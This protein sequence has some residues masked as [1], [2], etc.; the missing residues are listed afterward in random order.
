VTL[1][2]VVICYWRQG[3]PQLAARSVLL[4]VLAQAVLVVPLTSCL[5]LAAGEAQLLSR[6]EAAQSMMAAHYRC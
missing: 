3:H 1:V 6:P 2:L 5:V 4:P